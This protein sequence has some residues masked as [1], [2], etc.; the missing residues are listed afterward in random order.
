MLRT[1]ADSDAGQV[2]QGILRAAALTGVMQVIPAHDVHAY[3]GIPLLPTVMS[4]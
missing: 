2:R 1:L 3:D 4:Q